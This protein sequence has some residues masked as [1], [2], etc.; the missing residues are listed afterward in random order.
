MAAS[1]R[2][3]S[4]PG[5]VSLV[6]ALSRRTIEFMYMCWALARPMSLPS[7]KPCRVRSHWR[8]RSPVMVV[9]PFFRRRP[10]RRSWTLASTQTG[11]PPTASAMST[12]PAKSIIMKWSIGMSV[13]SIQVATVQ[14]GPPCW[15]LELILSTVRGWTVPSSG[16]VHS[17]MVTLVSRG[18]LSTDML[19]RSAERC[20]SICTSASGS[21]PTSF[22]APPSSTFRAEFRLSEP[23]SRMLTGERPAASVPCPSCLSPRLR[24]FLV[25]LPLRCS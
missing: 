1:A 5:S 20:S 19:R 10:D 16:S 25:R 14:P 7:P 21:R 18:M 11:T 22:R 6:P 4:L 8:A 15:R 23:S 12:T 13:S 9:V 24:G 3:R 2:E 17:G